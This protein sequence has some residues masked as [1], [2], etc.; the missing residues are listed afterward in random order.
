M[1]SVLRYGSVPY[2]EQSGIVL[3]HTH[4]L[5]IIIGQVVVTSL[6]AWVTILRGYVLPS[7][8]SFIAVCTQ[9]HGHTSLSLYSAAVKVKCIEL[10]NY[11][12]MG[13]GVVGVN[14]IDTSASD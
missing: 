2:L 6:G 7:N 5:I 12:W 1:I 4:E 3:L 11:S 13:W 14:I 9:C 10:P 8:S